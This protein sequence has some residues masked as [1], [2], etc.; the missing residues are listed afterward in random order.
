MLIHLMPTFYNP[1]S[2]L[3][4]SI[5]KLIFIYD[6][7]F[8]CE[9]P[10]EDLALKKPFPNKSY[11]VVCRRRKNKAFE[12]LYLHC[13]ENDVRKFTVYEEWE[14]NLNN[15][16]NYTHYHYIE[17]NLLDN[18]FEAISQNFL[19]WNEYKTEIHKNWIPV[20]CIP[21]MEFDTDVL[22]KGVRWDSDVEDGYYFDGIIKQRVE[23]YY[24]PTIPYENLLNHNQNKMPDLN[25]DVFNLTRG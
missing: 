16:Y 11:F 15:E 7:G 17:F 21:K 12:G 4:V 10:I 6:N 24:V 20:N 1:Y 23:R 25:I 13:K 3:N 2:N 8:E 14:T 18:N 9:I 19:I 5:K 22:K